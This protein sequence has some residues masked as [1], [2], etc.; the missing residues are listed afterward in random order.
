MERKSVNIFTIKWLGCTTSFITII[1][2]QGMRI[3]VNKNV[4]AIG[5][6]FLISCYGYSQSKFE[7]EFRIKTNEVP[8]IALSFVDSMKFESRVKWFKEIGLNDISIEAKANYK[9]QPISIEFS[10]NGLFEDIEIEVKSNQL[11]VDVFSKLSGV[12]SQRHEKYTIEKVQVQY[13]G[14]RNT[15][16]QFMRENRKIPEGITIN[17]ELVI[18]TKVDGNFRMLEYLFKQNGDYV[19]SNQILSNR[20]DTIDY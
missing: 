16:L 1:G 6:I 11:P 12:I 20:Q 2:K 5:L 10:G 13:T 14:D 19:K 8:S 3:F 4:F 15:V 17:Y 7:K 9:K 18:S